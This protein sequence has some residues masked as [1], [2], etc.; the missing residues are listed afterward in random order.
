MRNT[1]VAQRN[2]VM[3]VDPVT[4]FAFIGHLL[5]ATHCSASL[6][7]TA[8][9]VQVKRLHAYHSLLCKEREEK[10]SEEALLRK[11]TSRTERDDCV[12]VVVVVVVVVIA[13]I[14]GPVVL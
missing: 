9:Y 2:A 6:L 7:S 4:Q 3:K 14:M 12:V 10:F 1:C 13:V 8:V 5:P 11:L